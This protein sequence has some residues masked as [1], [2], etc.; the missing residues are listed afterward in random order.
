MNVFVDIMPQ[1]ANNGQIKTFMERYLMNEN[2]NGYFKVSKEELQTQMFFL[3]TVRTKTSEMIESF[4]KE[5]IDM[6]GPVRFESPVYVCSLVGYAAKKKGRNKNWQSKQT[7][8]R[9]GNEYKRDS[10]EYQ[11]LLDRAYNELSKNTGFR[12]ALLATGSATITHSIG[13][14]KSNETV[15]TQN[16]FCSRLLKIRRRLQEEK[17]EKLF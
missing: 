16:E 7:L 2:I 17:Q 14:N 5:R 4:L 12:N 13:R 11:E 1:K 10:K 6:F 15:L 3:E 9:R 8:Y